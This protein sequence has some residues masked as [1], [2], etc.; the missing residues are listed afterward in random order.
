MTGCGFDTQ[1]AKRLEDIDLSH[2]H[3][4]TWKNNL[5]LLALT[6]QV[7]TLSKE[8]LLIPV[9]EDCVGACQPRLV[10]L[11]PEWQGRHGL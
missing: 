3:V 11:S 9:P 10:S 2:R 7:P 1:I 8:M 5:V 4:M 6:D